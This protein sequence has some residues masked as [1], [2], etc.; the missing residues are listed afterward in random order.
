MRTTGRAD[1]GMSLRVVRG[2]SC[3]VYFLLFFAFSALLSFSEASLLR[4]LLLAPLPPSSS[5]SESGTYVPTILLAGP[6]RGGGC[7]VTKE[8]VADAVKCSVSEKVDCAA[9]TTMTVARGVTHSIAI[10]PTWHA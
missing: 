9:L 4:F 1:L 2:Q 5:S 8:R 7:D 6:V 10:C 3:S